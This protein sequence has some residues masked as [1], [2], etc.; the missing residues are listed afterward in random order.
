MEKFSPGYYVSQNTFKS[1]QP[2]AINRQWQ[3]VNPEIITLLSQ[4][5]RQL[6]RLDMFSN[7][8][9]SIDLFISMYILKEAT[10][11]SRIEGTQTNIEE[12]L[13]DA[14][15]IPP[16]K[17]D[18]WNEVQN[19]ILAMQEAIESLKSIPLSTRLIKQTH[20]VL[21]QGVR[22]EHKQPGEFRKSQNWIGGASIQD[23]V[24]VPPVHTSVPELM[25][26]LEKFMHNDGLQ[27]PELIKIAILHYQFETIHPFLDGNGR[28][29]RLLITLYLVQKE[30]LKKP[31]LYL[32]DFLEK[33]RQLY[34]DNLIRVREK[35]DLQQWIKFFL[36]GIVETAKNSIDTFEKILL[37]KSEVENLALSK[38]SRA[39]AIQMVLEHLYKKP[40]ITASIV[41]SITK[42]SLATSYSIVS[43]M[44]ELGILKENTGGKRNRSYIFINYINLYR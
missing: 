40:V 20:K 2:N 14:K 11:S 23:A 16:E 21:L 30:I 3:I 22:G 26:D 41:S 43:D 42:Q 36:V 19:Y 32:S 5:D 25:S 37:L 15:D 34:Y 10:K 27:I 17:R 24:F 44:E 35:N 29:G 33:N 13:H 12:A 6:G 4:A 31:I 7:Y 1:F 39:G 8:I 38:G 28:I 18:D 9:P